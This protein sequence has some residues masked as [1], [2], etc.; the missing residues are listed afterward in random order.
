VSSWRPVR[1]RITT[2]TESV[3]PLSPEAPSE[4]AFYRVRST[5]LD[6]DHGGFGN[7]VD[8]FSLQAPVLP[9]S[10]QRSP[11]LSTQTLAPMS[12]LPI[13]TIRCGRRS[14][15][16]TRH[17][18]R[19]TGRLAPC[20]HLWPGRRRVTSRSTRSTSPWSGVET[21]GWV[22]IC[23]SRRLL[24]LDHS[25][26][27]FRERMPTQVSGC[28]GVMTMRSLSVVSRSTGRTVL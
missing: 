18:R 1:S 27:M 3:F 11:P 17:C 25:V 20:P 6:P 9:S 16:A 5:D 4:T 12:P 14:A 19:P 23:S 2:S 13:G 28:L 10:S 21:P 15:C 7:L 8:S 22:V 26:S 24:L